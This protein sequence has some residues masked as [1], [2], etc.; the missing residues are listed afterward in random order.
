M[1]SLQGY[2]DK[3]VLVITADG[4]TILGDLKGFDQTTNVILSDSIERVYSLE[5]PVEEVPLG[6]FVVRGDNVTLVGELDGER[7]RE[8]DLSTIRAEPISELK[9]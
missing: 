8:M 3:R 4:R 6:L 7:E 2:I 5:E 9:I 1:S